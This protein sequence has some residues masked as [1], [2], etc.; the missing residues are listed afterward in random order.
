MRISDTVT[1]AGATACPHML[2]YHCNVGFPVVDAG[3]ELSYPAGE[4]T[5]VSDASTDAYRTLAA[6]RAVVRRGVLRARHGG[7][8]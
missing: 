3:A 5:C 1:N 2:L 7:E 6:P 8:S 4:G